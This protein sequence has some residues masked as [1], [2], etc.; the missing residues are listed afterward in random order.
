MINLLPSGLKSEYQF[1]RRN[2]QLRHWAFALLFGLIGVG[3]VA[4]GGMLYLQKSI[5][6][7]TTKVAT[8]EKSLKSQNLEETRKRTEA[9][10]SNL[11]LAGDVLSQEVLFSKLLTQIAAVTPSNTSLAE[12][13][14]NQVQGS[15]DISAISSDY[16]S[17]TQLQ[18]NLSDPKNK[19]FTKADIQNISCQ[20]NPTDP[21]YPC[22][23][24]IKALFSENNPFLFI[25][26]SGSKGAAR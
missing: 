18:V 13:N 4:T 22:N 26:K 9:I 10:S 17:A 20:P 16:A 21:R 6:D 25:N 11:K 3:L 14:I 7:Y 8:L 19:I 23:V 5:D 24:S 2:T 1:A 12:L 15:L